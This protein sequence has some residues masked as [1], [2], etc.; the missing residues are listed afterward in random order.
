MPVL[1][2]FGKKRETNLK[3]KE[4]LSIGCEKWRC[5]G[6]KERYKQI[7]E[8]L[9]GI[10]VYFL[11]CRRKSHPIVMFLGAG[12]GET[13][14]E[15]KKHLLKHKIHPTVDVFSLTK[16]LSSEVNSKTRRDYSNNLPFEHLNMKNSAFKN[17]E[18]K[19]DL[20]I[21]A[22]SVGVHTKYPANSLFTSALMLQKGGRAYIEVVDFLKKNGGISTI[23]EHKKLLERNKSFSFSKYERY[24]LSYMKQILVFKKVFL[25]MIEV[26]NPK[27]EFSIKMIDNNLNH[28]TCQ[29]NFIEVE[30]IK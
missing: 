13:I 29:M 3:V 4:W 21:G 24:S 27:L 19:Y 18:N 7:S 22:M 25:R 15:F 9:G 16:D 14:S 10:H 23:K 26:Y 12:V 28:F 2:K 20:V 6:L 1:K 5:N 30:R 17:L 11:V 8:A